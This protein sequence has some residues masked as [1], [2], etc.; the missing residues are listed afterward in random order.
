MVE[1]G[2]HLL[3]DSLQESRFFVI[4]R[5]NSLT[6]KTGA[7]LTKLKNVLWLKSLNL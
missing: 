3:R 1:E 4:C 7:L 5:V 6:K 2:N